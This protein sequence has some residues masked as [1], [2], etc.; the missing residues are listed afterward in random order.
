MVCLIYC[1]IIFF[2]VNAICARCEHLR[3]L[4]VKNNDFI[5]NEGIINLLSYLPVLTRLHIVRYVLRY[6]ILKPIFRHH[7]VYLLCQTIFTL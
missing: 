5:S 6:T 1:L 2:A 7:K 3:S 4:S